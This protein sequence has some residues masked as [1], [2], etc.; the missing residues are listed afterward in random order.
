MHARRLLLGLTLACGLLLGAANAQAEEPAQFTLVGDGMTIVVHSQTQAPIVVRGTMQVTT[1]QAWPFEAR[2]TQ[3]ATGAMQGSGE[4][5]A[6][7]RRV[8]FQVT[9]DASG[10]VRV[11][12][13]GTTYT[14]RRQAAGPQT[15]THATTD[16]E[17]TIRLEP[18]RIQDNTEL[19]RLIH[20]HTIYVPTG[21]QVKGG[22]YHLDSRQ[23]WQLIPSLGLSVSA[24]DGREVRFVPHVACMDRQIGGRR[25]PD[26]RALEGLIASPLRWQHKDIAR[27]MRDKLIPVLWTGASDARI[28]NIVSLPEYRQLLNKNMALIHKEVAHQQSIANRFNTG[29]RYFANCDVVAIEAEFTLQGKRYEVLRIM[30]IAWSG[31]RKGRDHSIGWQTFY[32]VCYK[33]PLGQLQD[34]YRLLRTISKSAQAMPVWQQAMAQRRLVIAQTHAN[35]RADN[36]RTFRRINEIHRSTA[37]AVRQIIAQGYANRTAI[38]DATHAKVIRGIRETNLVTPP[39]STT[40][41]EVSIHWDKV[42]S[43]GNAIILSKDPKYDPGPGWQ[44]LQPTN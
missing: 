27:F 41:I 14:L 21:W 36:L 26:G 28:R 15:Q 18:H 31:R 17:A 22:T 30:S 1:S 16:G 32:D 6:G 42:Y 34:S 40:P 9:S 7:R 3:D 38:R 35:I 10:V 39:G 11:L 19:Q 37:V 33:A 29:V 5:R 4:V 20:S 23:Y 25:L 44:V 13:A 12:L 8:P 2:L 24:P 43:N